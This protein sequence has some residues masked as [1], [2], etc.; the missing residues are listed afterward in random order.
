[1]LTTLNAPEFERWQQVLE[2]VRLDL[3]MVLYES[4]STPTHIYFPTSAIASLL[5]VTQ[6]GAT[7]EIAVVGREGVVGISILMGGD[8]TPGRAVVKSAGEGWRVRS[9]WVKS[10]C[11]RSPVLSLFLRYIQTLITQMSQTAVCNRHHCIDQQ[12]C[13]SLLLTLDRMDGN[14]MVMTQELI[15]NMLGVRREGITEVAIKLQKAGLI[16]YT[17][18]RI[19]VLNRL[20]LERRSCECYAVVKHEYDRLL[21]GLQQH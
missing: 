14:Q 17:R 18:G 8:T 5:Y 21:P 3:G 16:R 15:S 20:A 1:M 12:L 6:D 7:A 13:R 2:P 4:G 11:L 10:E 19:T 9:N